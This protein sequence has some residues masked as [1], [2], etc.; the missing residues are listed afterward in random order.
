VSAED[1]IE[2]YAAAILEVARGEGRLDRVGDELYRISR[3][4][5]SS[6]ELR[7]AL[8]DPRL[9]VERKIGV[10]EDLLGSRVLPLTMNLVSFVIASGRAGDLPAIADRLAARSAA[11]RDRVIAEVRSAVEL[12]DETL[13]RLTEALNR[14]TGKQ[15]Q[16]KAVVDPSVIGGLVARVGD[17]VID[18]SVRRRF[19][20]LRQQLVRD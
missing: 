1:R 10:V 19:D 7:E 12:D 14:A 20:D 6:I 11:E 13:A 17:T 5:E 15:V 2:G 3:T 16:I 8:S 18:G 4:F 9:P